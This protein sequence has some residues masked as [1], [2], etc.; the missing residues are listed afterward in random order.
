MKLEF[1]L[2][3]FSISREH[4]FLENFIILRKQ[5]FFNSFPARLLNLNLEVEVTIQLKWDR[6]ILS[7]ISK[8]TIASKCLRTNYK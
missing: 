1:D 2:W 5:F 8:L 6:Y 7:V 4:Y 3:L